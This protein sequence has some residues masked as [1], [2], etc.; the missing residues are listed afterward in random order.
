MGQRILPPWDSVILMMVDEYPLSVKSGQL[1]VS[2]T[3]PQQ[4]QW[5]PYVTAVDTQRQTACSGGPH[6]VATGLAC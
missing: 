4:V 5:L 3:D 1:R 6:D 2:Q